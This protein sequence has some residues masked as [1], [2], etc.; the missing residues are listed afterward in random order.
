MGAAPSGHATLEGTLRLVSGSS[1][2]VPK[3]DNS[4]G[5]C[6]AALVVLG[7]VWGSSMTSLRC[8]QDELRGSHDL[9]PT[10][11]MFPLLLVGKEVTGTCSE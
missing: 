3:P 9:H 8:A 11:W 2:P 1:P 6:S 4:V 10:L 5:F 7:C